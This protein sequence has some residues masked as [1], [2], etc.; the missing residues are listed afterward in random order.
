MNSSWKSLNIYV[1]TTGEECPIYIDT[2]EKWEAA[3]VMLTD[4]YN[5]KPEGSIII[6]RRHISPNTRIYNSDLSGR[7]MYAESFLGGGAVTPHAYKQIMESDLITHTNP[8]RPTYD[9]LLV[10][11]KEWDKGTS[12]TSGAKKF[13]TKV[14]TCTLGTHWQRR[15][16]NLS[17]DWENPYL[18]NWVG[19]I[20]Q[21]IRKTAEAV[22]GL[23]FVMFKWDKKYLTQRPTNWIVITGSKVIKAS[24]SGHVGK[25]LVGFLASQGAIIKLANGFFSDPN[26][27][28]HY[29]TAQHE[30]LHGL[31]IKHEHQR[32]D[33]QV[34][35]TSKSDQTKQVSLVCLTPYDPTSILHY[36]AHVNNACSN[37]TNGTKITWD[38]G[39]QAISKNVPLWG[40]GHQ[41]QRLRMSELDKLGLNRLYPPC[42][43]DRESLTYSMKND[44]G[45]GKNYP[46]TISHSYNPKKSW[47]TDLFYCGRRVMEFHNGFGVDSWV[48]TGDS[49]QIRGTDGRCGPTNGANCPSC[50]VLD[51]DQIPTKNSDGRDVWQGFTGMFY[52]GKMFGKPNN[53]WDGRCGWN[54]GP[55]CEACRK[56]TS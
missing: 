23:R 41:G 2:S 4:M 50:R 34:T 11:K 53:G 12:C 19:A 6:R 56:L 30:L 17:V 10:S 36:N 26:D 9:D 8:N 35:R 51:N 25:E 7:I 22:P 33:A 54:N 55:S 40:K 28:R 37:C 18:S 14:S 32:H 27:T 46:K 3:I 16:V 29:G 47:K 1:V 13:Y 39:V 31:G 45:G 52:C 21:S 24:T 44:Y 43:V 20:E 5:L 42:L 48:Q 49:W 15:I 38:Q